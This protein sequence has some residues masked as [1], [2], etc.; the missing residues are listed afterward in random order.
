MKLLIRYI[1]KQGQNNIVEQTIVERNKLKIGRGTDQN[2]LLPDRRVALGHAKFAVSSDDIKVSTASGKY[3]LFNNQMV[4]KCSLTVGQHVD[5]VGHIITLFAGEQGCDF[6]IEV[7]L[8]NEQQVSLKDRYQTRLQELN[9]GKRRWSWLFFLTVIICCLIVPIAGVLNPPIM[10]T[11]RDSPLPD[12]G[13]WMAGK[14]MKSHQFMGD[15]CSECHVDAFV[16]VNNQQCQSC[17]NETKHHVD[18]KGI[19]VSFEAFAECTDCHKEHNDERTLE[20]YSQQVCVTCHQDSEQ[21][22]LK[23]KN[24]GMVTDFEKQHPSFNATMLVPNKLANRV[25]NTK[26]NELLVSNTNEL[27]GHQSALLQPSFNDSFNKNWLSQKVLLADDSAKEQ[28]NLNFPHKLHMDP[29]GIN[30]ATDK[31]ILACASC[32]EPEKGGLQMKPITME[33]HCQSCHTLT[34]DADDPERVVPHGSPTDVVMMMREY[35]AFRYIYQ[36]LNIDDKNVIQTAGDLFSVRQARRPGRDKKLR[37]SFEDSM[38]S[39]TIASIEKLTKNTVRTDALLWAE[40]RASNAAFDMFE[41]QACAV[42]HVVT[43]TEDDSET[44]DIP[45]QVEP[46][47]LTKTWLPASRFS[48]DEH[49]ATQCVDCHQAQS[50]EHSSDILIPDVDNCRQCHG[51]EQSDNLIPNTCIDCHDFHQA[52]LQHFTYAEKISA[53]SHVA[54]SMKTDN[55]HAEKALAQGEY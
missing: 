41:R 39:Q 13:Q 21:T 7:K 24:R 14:L 1:K 15:N 18:V 23:D 5:I 43:K 12:D 49:Q 44:A 55:F 29:E 28:S 19:A 35:Y 46:V 42:C 38:D 20:Q 27:T 52:K 11:L 9:I 50:S 8:N 48:H 54:D 17:H 4:K 25:V 40:S 45:W 37:K 30:S 36:Q 2:I 6:V 32:H 34:F 53:K 22:G 16:Q 31:V 47:V 33:K 3:V 51:G 26:D 10:E